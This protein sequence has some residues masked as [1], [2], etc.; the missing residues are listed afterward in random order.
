MTKD[1]VVYAAA[2][3]MV[4]LVAGFFGANR[5]N[6]SAAETAPVAIASNSGKTDQV[7][8][9]DHPSIGGTTG[10]APQPQGG[11]LPQVT[12]AIEKAKQKPEDF[13]AQMTAGDLYYQIQRFDDARKLYTAANKLKPEDVEPLVKL[14]NVNFDMEKYDEAEKWYDAALKK[15]P[16]QVSVRTDYG[17]T[18]FLRTPRDIDRAIK[19]YQTSLGINP[20]HEITLQNLVVAYTEKGDT[21]S[22]G[23][24]LARL[25]KVNPNNPAVK[26]AGGK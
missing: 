15:D 19:E 18:F 3:L 4:G 11:A 1:K 5:L 22:A 9:P 6:R 21:Q 26:A 17:L 14:G 10:A 12:E 2:G 7:L 13:E 16:T 24:T 20:N 23:E 25:A 8:P